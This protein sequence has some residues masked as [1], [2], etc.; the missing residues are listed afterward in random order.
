MSRN[1][2][3]LAFSSDYRYQRVV[4]RGAVIALGTSQ[5]ITHNLGYKPF[6][7]VAAEY[8]DGDYG[9]VSNAGQTPYGT[10]G[11]AISVTYTVSDTQLTIAALDNTFGGQTANVYYKIYA[12]ALS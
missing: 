5:A 4:Q 3:K 9:T 8:P 12:D 11:G 1:D 7:R 2:D 6:V 10:A